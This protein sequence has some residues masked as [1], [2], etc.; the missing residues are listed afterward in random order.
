VRRFSGWLSRLSHPSK[1]RKTHRNQHSGKVATMPPATAGGVEAN[2]RRIYAAQIDNCGAIGGGEAICPSIADNTTIPGAG[3]IML[4]TAAPLVSSNTALDADELSV[5]PPTPGSKSYASSS[6]ISKEELHRAV[7]KGSH[8]PDSGM[9]SSSEIPAARRWGA[10]R[11][12]R[13]RRY[14]FPRRGF[15]EKQ[16]Q[17]WRRLCPW[18]RFRSHL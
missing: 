15:R 13:R 17:L 4:D 7:W 12:R 8:D 10:P 16:E 1:I 14:S 6:A 3:T 11:K 9:A 2:G 5:N 18:N